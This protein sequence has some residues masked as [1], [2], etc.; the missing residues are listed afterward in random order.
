MYY[1]EQCLKWW[2]KDELD[3]GD[4]CPNCRAI[5]FLLKAN[6]MFA[7]VLVP[8][9]KLFGTKTNEELMV[10]N[11]LAR[12]RLETKLTSE[13]KGI[14]F[15]VLCSPD[16]LKIEIYPGAKITMSQLEDIRKSSNALMA[17][18]LSPHNPEMWD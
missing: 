1:C 18:E 6:Q 4:T 14:I 12:Q 13:F 7:V 16:I 10:Y 5:C 9:L 3:K 8:E 2:E 17:N 15:K 11:D